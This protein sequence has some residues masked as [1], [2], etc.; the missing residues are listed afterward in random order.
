MN[1][2]ILY[3]VYSCWGKGSEGVWVASSL[4]LLALFTKARIL[5]SDS[6]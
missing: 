4:S 2:G 3:C 1:I 6:L 5:C